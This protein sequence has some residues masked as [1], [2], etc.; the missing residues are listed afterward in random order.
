MCCRY[1]VDP[2]REGRLDLALSGESSAQ[3]CRLLSHY[4]GRINVVVDAIGDY[5]AKL[6]RS[7]SKCWVS[8]GYGKIDKVEG[9]PRQGRFGSSIR[10]S[11]FFPDV[12][13]AS[14][15]VGDT[16]CRGR[17]SPRLLSL[18][19]DSKPDSQVRSGAMET[20]EYRKHTQHAKCLR[21]F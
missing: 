11:E 8:Q 9:V 18:P 14:A 16:R 12:N 10:A 17:T 7:C 13:P 6:D 5:C 15:A 1:V 4:I 19:K 20:G 3:A 2:W 21:G